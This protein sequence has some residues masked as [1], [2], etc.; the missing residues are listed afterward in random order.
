ITFM[1]FR[2]FKMVSYVVFGRGSFNQLDEILAPHRKGEAPMIF[3]VDHF[4]EGKALLN[5][6]PLRGK[7][8]VILA[9]VTHEPKTTQVDALAKA[10]KDEFGTI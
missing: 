9:D 7:D 10:I 3:L 2:N 8:K 4:F 6:V 5:R 1:S